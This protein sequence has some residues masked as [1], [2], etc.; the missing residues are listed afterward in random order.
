MGHPPAPPDPP[1]PLE[2]PDPLDPPLPAPPSVCMLALSSPQP[3]APTRQKTSPKR[4]TGRIMAI[5]SSPARAG[6][7]WLPAGSVRLDSDRDT[8]VGAARPP[9]DGRR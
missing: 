8:T 2:P 5:L 4:R 3:K 1:D 6:A 9:G 7:P